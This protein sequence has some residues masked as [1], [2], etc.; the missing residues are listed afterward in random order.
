MGV[1]VD[2]KYINRGVH[3]VELRLGSGLRLKLGLQL[4]IGMEIRVEI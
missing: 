2:C 1:R 4:G 3:D